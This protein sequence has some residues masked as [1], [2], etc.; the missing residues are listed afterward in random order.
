LYKFLLLTPLFLDFP[1]LNVVIL[2]RYSVVRGL[3]SVIS[4]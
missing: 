3:M 1:V 2:Q 4:H